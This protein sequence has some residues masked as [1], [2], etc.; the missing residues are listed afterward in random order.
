MVSSSPR[1]TTGP[2]VGSISRRTQRPTVDLPEPD[3]P[4]SPSVRPARRVNDTPETACT[5]DLMDRTPS[6][7]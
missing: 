7:T 2:D 4:T 1:N 6:A 3:S 5:V